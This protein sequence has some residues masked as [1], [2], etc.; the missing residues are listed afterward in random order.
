MYAFIL[1]LMEACSQKLTQKFEGC[2]MV[3]RP[4]WNIPILQCGVC[5][6]AKSPHLKT[7]LGNYG[8]GVLQTKEEKDCLDRLKAKYLLWYRCLSAHGRGISKGSINAERCIKV[9]E[10]YMLPSRQPHFLGMSLIIPAT[11]C[12]TTFCMRY[13][14]V[15]S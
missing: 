1:N 14:S 4:E 11:Q 5:Y 13:N 9:L 3:K 10:Q 6:W 2:G 15:A 12:Q 8:H 7:I